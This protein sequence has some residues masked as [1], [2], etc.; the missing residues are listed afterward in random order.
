[1]GL[2]SEKFEQTPARCIDPPGNC[3]LSAPEHFGDILIGHI[4]ERGQDNRLSLKIAQFP[5]SFQDQG[6][7][8][9]ILYLPS[10]DEFELPTSETPGAPVCKCLDRNS[11]KPGRKSARSVKVPDSPAYARKGLGREVLGWLPITAHAIQKSE[12]CWMV[13]AY[14]KFQRLQVTA[15]SLCGQLQI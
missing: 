4:F 9:L 5:K 7:S 3:A 6:R 10:A 14:E 13:A 15:S 2:P 8:I 1:M 12:N 11:I